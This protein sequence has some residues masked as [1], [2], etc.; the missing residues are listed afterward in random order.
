MQ[1]TKEQ[2]IRMIQALPDD[3]SVDDVL[4]EIYF[5]IQVD[6]GLDELDQGRGIPHEEVEARISKW[7]SP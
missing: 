6:A 5:R 1:G 3:A 7:T 4:S 2:V